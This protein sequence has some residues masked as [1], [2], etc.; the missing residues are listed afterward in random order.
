MATGKRGED[1]GLAAHT[2]TGLAPAQQVDGRDNQSDHQQQMDQSTSHVKT[3]TQKPEDDQNR[4][5]CPK[6]RL[7]VQGRNLACQA[8]R[9]CCLEQSCPVKNAPTT[10]ERSKRREEE[11]SKKQHSCIS[12]NRRLSRLLQ[13]P[14][15]L[16]TPGHTFSASMLDL[17]ARGESLPNA[18]Q[19]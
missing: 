7:T 12:T 5:D 15:Q 10:E 4:N 14:Q 16:G 1:R 17:R 19:F 6:H 8:V 3:P 2:L 18:N 11:G 9:S 13:S